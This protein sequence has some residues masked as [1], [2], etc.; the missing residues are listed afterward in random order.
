MAALGAVLLLLG[1]SGC[2]DNHHHTSLSS[3][4]AIKKINKESEHHKK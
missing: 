2:G 3:A 4:G 1:T